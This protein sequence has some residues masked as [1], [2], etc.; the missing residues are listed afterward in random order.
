MQCQIFL[1]VWQCTWKQLAASVM[2]P[3]FNFGS[4]APSLRDKSS[5]ETTLFLSSDDSSLFLLNSGSCPSCSW[6]AGGFIMGTVSTKTATVVFFHKK[7]TFKVGRLNLMLY[8]VFI[9][10]T[11][12]LMTFWQNARFFSTKK[13]N[14][15]TIS[16]RREYQGVLPLCP[17]TLRSSWQKKVSF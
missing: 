17:V 8:I 6:S 13:L 5:I 7:W 9:V 14:G 11:S 10:G 16:G 4:R 2:A 1:I 15:T 3:C 12:N